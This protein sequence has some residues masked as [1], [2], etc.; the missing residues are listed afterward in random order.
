VVVENGTVE[1]RCAS[2]VC[3]LRA[4]RQ[5]RRGDLFKRAFARELSVS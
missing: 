3:G 4:G 1:L 2:S 5:E